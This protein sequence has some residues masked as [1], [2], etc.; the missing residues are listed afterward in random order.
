MVERFLGGAVAVLGLVWVNSAAAQEPAKQPSAAVGQENLGLGVGVGF[1]N[2]N[3]P[4]LRVGA[5]AIALDVSAG[6]TVAALSYTTPRPDTGA[7]FSASNEEPHI[8]FL[9]PL[10]VTPQVLIHV[11]TLQR[12]IRGA[13]RFG[14]RYNVA[15]GHGATLGGQVGKRWGHFLLEGL[16]GISI[17]PTADDRLRD[18]EVVPAAASFKFPP[19][20]GYGLT[21][22]FMYFP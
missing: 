18:R 12:E 7:L 10:E 16:W 8:K 22:N 11:G 19:A 17:Y 5:R 15:L 20:L 2:P 4:V 3:G 9:A 13:L 1:F 21:V 14:Y 6:Y